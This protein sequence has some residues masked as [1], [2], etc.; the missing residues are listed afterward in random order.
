VI[1][2]HGEDA[3]RKVLGDQIQQR[4]GLSPQLPLMGEVVEL[5]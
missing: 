1:L 4:F 3:P 5:Q 2:T